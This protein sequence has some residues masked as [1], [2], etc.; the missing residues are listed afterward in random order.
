[1]SEYEL[2]KPLPPQEKQETFYLHLRTKI[3]NFVDK[4]NFPSGDKWTSY[5]L[6]APDLFYLLMKSMTDSRID[7]KDKVLIGSG[8]LYFLT[9]IDVLPEGLIGPG[10]FMD[11]IV[12]ATFV[13][14]TLLNKLPTNL[15]E[16]HWVGDKSLLSSLQKLT[17]LSDSLFSKLPARSLLGK[18]MKKSKPKK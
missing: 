1:M 10:G 3:T 12:V 9:P 17:N 7:G 16:E 2:S 4:K 18:F 8:I 6:F 13:V 11:D 5:L 14:N 15:L